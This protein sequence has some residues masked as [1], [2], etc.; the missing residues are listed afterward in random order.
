MLAY[1]NLFLTKIL[2]D[3]ML[4]IK[5]KVSINNLFG[6]Y[7]NLIKKIKEL[8]L[9]SVCGGE[10]GIRTHGAIPSSHDFES[11]AI[12]QTLPSLHN[13]NIIQY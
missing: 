6:T 2:F 3:Y 10:S 1:N 5:H 4:F 13:L 12:D 9:V 7:F 8:S 11:C